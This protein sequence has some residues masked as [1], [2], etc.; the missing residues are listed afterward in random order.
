MARLKFLFTLFLSLLLVSAL[1][2]CG[3]GSG[4]SV[5]NNG[6]IGGTGVTAA[7]TITGFGSIFVNGI[8]FD[9]SNSAFDV[10]GDGNANETD[11]ALGMFVSVTGTIN[12]DGTSGTADRVV[13]DDAI[14]G[15][16]SAI[17]MDADGQTKSLTVF[18]TTIQ[19]DKVTTTY[20]NT[21][22]ASLAVDDVIEVSGFTDQTGILH[23]TRI[24]KK[25]N[26]VAGVSEVEIK[27]MVSG[28]TGTTFVLGSF[29]VDFSGPVDLS[30]LPNGTVTNGL[31]VEVKGTLNGSII[32]ASRIEQEDDLFG[33][34]VNKVSL[35]GIVTD[36]TGASSFKIAGQQIDASAATL[37][38]ST[39]ILTNGMEVEVEG[40]VINGLLQ[41]T[42]VKKR[43]GKIKLAATV[44]AVSTAT[45]S[46]TLQLAPGTVVIQINNQTQ[47]EDE[48]SS[49]TLTLSGINPGTDYL[50]L[51]G[52][53]DTSGNII[54]SKIKRDHPDKDIVQAPVDSFV[55]GNTITVLGLTFS[56]DSSTEFEL[57]D[58]ASTDSGTFYM[59]LNNG[60]LV[61]IKDKNHDGTADEVE[62]EN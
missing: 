18:D 22:F 35:E 30:D 43:G 52:Y 59:N 2:S 29:S 5:A 13:F 50:E 11:L 40:P 28:L 47:F 51:R 23:A 37:E 9:T 19:A 53:L 45:S 46:I 3:G 8:E 38:P 60:D 54:A 62:I 39:L 17:T 41:A 34:N 33:D 15:R 16:I 36:L 14:Q 57:T 26:F 32:S 7:G 42:K 21:A 20:Q 44:A 27:G 24:E 31:Q 6:G 58:D 25:E 48:L 55:I 4:N 56:T 49:N 61:K 10:D 12:A 1:G